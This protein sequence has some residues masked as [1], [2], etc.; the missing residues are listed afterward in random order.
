M[1][2]YNTGKPLKVIQRDAFVDLVDAGV[3]RA[4][5]DDFGAER[6][7]EAAVRGAAAGARLGLDAAV[8]ADRRDG[9]LAQR[10]VA[11][12]ER[13]AGQ[14][15]SSV[16]SMPCARR[17]ASTRSRN[18]AAV[19]AVPKRKLNTASQFAGHHV[20]GAG[21]GV[22]VGDLKRG[23]RERV[24]A[25][26]PTRRREFGQRRCERVDRIA[27]QVR[28]GDVTL[29][30]VHVQV[31]GQ[32]AAPT[33]AD[34]VAEALF[35]R[36]LADH[37]PVDALAA[38]AKFLGDAAHAVDRAAFLVRGQQQRD[39]A[40]DGPGARARTPPAR[41]PS[42]RHRISCPPRRGR[43]DEECGQGGR[44]C[45][46]IGRSECRGTRHG[47]PLR[48]VATGCRLAI[49]QVLE[50]RPLQ[51]SAIRPAPRRCGRGSDQ[52]RYRPPPCARPQ[53][54][55]VAVAQVLDREAGRARGARRSAP[56]NRR[57]PAS[58]DARADQFA[59]EIENRAHR[60][61]MPR[62]NSVA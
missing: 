51:A 30:A 36:R 12:Q 2:R 38:A 52:H 16:K 3:D 39:A 53:V 11:G 32:R 5:L 27:R 54:V 62:P 26:V 34:Q 60:R 49:A 22:E 59:G 7:D 40:G 50:R 33:D 29:H 56:G 18:S 45:F 47:S 24:V 31:P 48:D 37:A 1:A 14:P 44:F 6:R 9:R 46:A 15:Q 17:I 23:R 13:L 58:T 43:R 42:R 57:R 10:A 35:R 55:D 4:E 61:L 21:A 19:L 28:I 25:L 8:L 41:R 20:V